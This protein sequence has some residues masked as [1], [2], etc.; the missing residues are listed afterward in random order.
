LTPVEAFQS[1]HGVPVAVNE[2]GA[3]RWTPGAAQFIDDEMALMALFEERAMNH[4]LWVWDPDWRPWNEGVNAFTFRFGPDPDNDSEVSSSALLEVIRGYWGR[5]RVRPSQ[6]LTGKSFLPMVLTA[7]APLS[8]PL[9]LAEVSYW[10]YQIQDAAGRG[11]ADGL[12][13]SH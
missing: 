8:E 1:E 3:V 12:A 6:P 9:P 11:A 7:S 13:A 4:A 10:A 5:N 2:F